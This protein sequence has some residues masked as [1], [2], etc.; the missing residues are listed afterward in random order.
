MKKDLSG[1]VLDYAYEFFEE[2]KNDR[3]FF[4]MRLIS[5]HEFTGENNWYIDEQLGRFLR[6][7]ESSGH[8][9]KTLLMIYSD[10]GDH[11]DYLLWNT[12]SG[13]AEMIN[14]IFFVVIPEVL[15]KEIGKTV[16]AN[17]QKLISHFEIFRSPVR[18]WGKKIDSH[19]VAGPDI[20]YQVID[21]RRTCK[22]AKVDFE[23][24]CYPKY[25]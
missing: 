15:D 13:Y 5:A 23:C 19:C 8:L 18:Y 7:F 9:N 11:I 1:L 2:Y 16:E 6:K 25:D 14:P 4:Q 22:E 3:K 17:Q 12:A 10:H 21:A 24:H 20:F